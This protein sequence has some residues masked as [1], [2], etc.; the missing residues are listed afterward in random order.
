MQ[1]H[2]VQKQGSGTQVPASNG[3]DR[4]YTANSLPCRGVILPPESV[5]VDSQRNS[6]QHLLSR[7]IEETGE[8]G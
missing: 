7:H 3:R 4:I 8:G 2:C 1:E 5:I 6:P